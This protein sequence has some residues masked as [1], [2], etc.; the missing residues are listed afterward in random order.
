[1]GPHGLEL[2]PQPTA[3]A[4]IGEIGLILMVLEAGLEVDL[5]QLAL[6]GKRGIVV[7]V[8]GSLCPLLLGFAVAKAFGL[9]T[10]SAL[11]VGASLAPTSMGISLKVLQDG[12]VL[13]TPTGQLIIAA[14]VIDDVIALVLLSEL[15]ALEDPT[16]ENFIVPIA[17]SLAFIFGVG[18]AAIRLVP[19]F[20]ANV[21]VPRLPASAIE[22]V[23][24][25]MV[26]AAGYAIM[27]ACHY[28]RSSHLLGAFLG[29]LCFCTLTSVKHVWKRQVRKILGWLVKIF[30]ACTIGFEVPIRDLW[31]GRVLSRAAAFLV[32]ALGKVGTGLFAKPFNWREAKIIGFAMAAWGEFAFIVATASREAGTLDADTY[33]AVV[34]A[35]LLSAIYSPFATKAACD[36]APDARGARRKKFLCCGPVNDAFS[37]E[38]GTLNGKVLHHV[39]FSCRVRCHGTW[40]LTDRILK[41]LRDEDCGVDLLDFQIHR[42]GPWAEVNIALRD[43]EILAPLD[44]REPGAHCEAINGKIIALHERL[45]DA[46]GIREC[47]SNVAA[48]ATAGAEEH[49]HKDQGEV[50]VERWRPHLDD[51]HPEDDDDE[52]FRQAEA[53]FQAAQTH[54]KDAAAAAN[55]RES[56]RARLAVAAAAMAAAVA[57]SSDDEDGLRRRNVRLSSDNSLPTSPRAS[58]TESRP[59]GVRPRTASMVD[60]SSL[61]QN[62]TDAMLFKAL[63][64]ARDEEQERREKETRMMGARFGGPAFASRRA[65]K[66]RVW[67]QAQSA[68]RTGALELDRSFTKPR[69]Q[70]SAMSPVEP[71]G[72]SSI[73]LTGASGATLAGELM[74]ILAKSRTAA[75]SD[76]GLMPTLHEG[77]GSDPEAAPRATPRYT[78]SPASD[79]E[80]APRSVSHFAAEA[81]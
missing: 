22:S 52:A 46:A 74:S 5:S 33:G 18:F 21:I 55:P 8:A 14:A 10:K 47:Q 66:Q 53:L 3:L 2:A 13:S 72:T 28:G 68:N 19:G 54:L 59:L 32:A 29:G 73:T 6:V 34:L 57:A 35:V 1:M 15:R 76:G 9:A 61:L 26:L 25:G 37:T 38:E 36:S 31:N 58:M 51:E 80:V 39:Y 48:G 75:G 77:G 50:L 65:L 60:L 64:E 27:A 69:P 63:N 43:R 44:D 30:F 56:E 17:A 67:A 45:V 24:L 20:L 4:L 41:R 78:E 12:K 7:A 23:L 40:G 49:Q 70:S 79:S 81:P 62:S 16:A 42:N 11:A 71:S